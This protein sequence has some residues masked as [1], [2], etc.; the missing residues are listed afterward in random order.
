M[1]MTHW[2]VHMPALESQHDG[3]A[4]QIDATQAEQLVASGPP[5]VHLSCPPMDPSEHVSQTLW[6]ASGTSST[7]LWSHVSVQQ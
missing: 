1:A 2:S 4:W 3:I 6:Q 7:Q 5:A